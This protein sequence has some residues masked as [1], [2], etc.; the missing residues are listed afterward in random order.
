MDRAQLDL[1][2]AAH[3]SRIGLHSTADLRTMANFNWVLWGM[4]T[5]LRRDPRHPG[6]AWATP[7]SKRKAA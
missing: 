6:G 7:P 3:Y 5:I 1:F 4:K 2:I